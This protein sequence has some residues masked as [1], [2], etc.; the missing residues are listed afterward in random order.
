MK[1]MPFGDALILVIILSVTPL[2]S[3]GLIFSIE[4]LV[5][6]LMVSIMIAVLL[7]TWILAAL[8][9]LTNLMRDY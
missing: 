7:I 5:S 9:A 4:G 3:F 8:S 2:M 1:G 6:V